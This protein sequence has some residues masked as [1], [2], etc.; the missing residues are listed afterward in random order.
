MVAS[1]MIHPSTPAQSSKL[2]WNTLRNLLDEDKYVVFPILLL[3]RNLFYLKL[4][5][6]LF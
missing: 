1:S 6:C 4:F 5:F 3:L 2:N